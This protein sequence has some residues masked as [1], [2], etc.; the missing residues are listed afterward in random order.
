[1]ASTP[2]PPDS[3]SVSIATAEADPSTW[4]TNKDWTKHRALIRE[5]YDSQ[6]L[7][8]VMKFMESKHKFKATSVSQ[9]NLLELGLTN[10]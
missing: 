9:T 5:L 3:S 1:M 8:E 6:P 4:A 2:W 7:A 10:F